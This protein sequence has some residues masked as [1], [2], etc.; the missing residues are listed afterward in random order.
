[1]TKMNELEQALMLITNDN[2]R[3]ILTSMLSNHKIQSMTDFAYGC[4]LFCED[5]MEKQQF[6]ALIIL[7][8]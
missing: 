4:F 6:K 2:A 8:R 3:K 1:M 5:T 7:I